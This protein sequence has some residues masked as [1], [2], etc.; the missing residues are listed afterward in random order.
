MAQKQI[1]VVHAPIEIANIVEQSENV[2]IGWH[3]IGNLS[4]F[5]T[6]EE[7]KDKYRTTF[8][9]ASDPAV[10]VGAGILYRF[11]YEI[12]KGDY[13]LTPLKATR[14]VLIGRVEGDYEF[15][16]S[17]VSQE[18]PNIRR[19][20]WTN[21]ISRDELSQSFR[22]AIGGFLTVFTVSDYFSELEVIL[23]G[24]PIA[25]DESQAIEAQQPATL[26]YDDIRFKA[27]ELISDQLTNINAYS[28]Q[29]LVAGI[30]RAMGFKTRVSPPGPDFGVDIIAHPDDFGFQSPKIKVQVKHR[31]G[32]AGAPEVRQLG[33]TLGSSEN[34]LF[35][36]TG[37]FTAEAYR[38]AEKQT[39]ITLI[40]HEQLVNLLLENYENLEPE[41]QAL[42]PLKK[43]YIP[44]V[45]T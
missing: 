19:V 15:N 14:E 36:S 12:K 13:I 30:L 16:P 23:K 11:V 7:L 22:Y 34:G 17:M 40:N 27:D 18:Y 38:E 2:A 9:D 21:K 45:S 43:V 31:K 8:T 33:G 35:V 5:N 20:K 29:G 24:K 28:F 25:K 32:P 44:M 26:L 1:W 37:G 39:R 3:E 41:F 6:R 4:N 10:W 42:V